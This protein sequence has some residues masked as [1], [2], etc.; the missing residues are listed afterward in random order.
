MAVF[1]PRQRRVNDTEINKTNQKKKKR[2]CSK[3][4]VQNVERQSRINRCD[5][6]LNTNKKNPRKRIRIHSQSDVQNEIY[7]IVCAMI[8]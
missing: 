1:V 3:T 5:K 8:I 2:D 6:Y 4:K 7:M